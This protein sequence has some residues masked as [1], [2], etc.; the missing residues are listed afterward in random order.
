MDPVVYFAMVTPLS[1][2]SV[3][4]G[5]LARTIPVCLLLVATVSAS[6]KWKK[7]YESEVKGEWENATKPAQR[8][9][10]PGYWTS[11]SHMTAS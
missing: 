10:S 5:I 9:L 7:F 3:A 6:D 4:M 2:E 8:V 11:A 1:V